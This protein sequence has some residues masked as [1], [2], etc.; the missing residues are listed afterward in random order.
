MAAHVCDEGVHLSRLL[1]DLDPVRHCRR[2]RSLVLRLL[3][4]VIRRGEHF[5]YS[6]SEPYLIFR[7]QIEYVWFGNPSFGV[8]FS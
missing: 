3:P 1:T 5:F 2:Q 7:G 8:L 4:H 6:A